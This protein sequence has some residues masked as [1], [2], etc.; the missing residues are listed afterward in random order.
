MD[1]KEVKVEELYGKWYE[2]CV[3]GAVLTIEENTM[4]YERKDKTVRSPYQ[5]RKDKEGHDLWYFAAKDIPSTFEQIIYHPSF[6][7]ELD[8]LS[9]RMAMVVYDMIYHPKNF[10]R[11]PYK[12]PEY[13]EI[14]LN[15]DKKAIKWFQDYRIRKLKFK[16]QEPNRESGMMAPTPPYFGF[17]SYEIERTEE[18]GGIIRA[19][20][21]RGA[22]GE[23]GTGSANRTSFG[24]MMMANA[25]E[26]LQCPEVAMTPQEMNQFELFVCN[27]KIDQL[28]G[29]NEWQD[30]VPS[31]TESFD[32]SIQFY[33]ESYHARAN[34][35]FFLPD[36]KKEI[37]SL[38]MYIFKLLVQAGLDYVRNEFH[39]TKPMLRIP[40]GNVDDYLIKMDTRDD[41]KRKGE[42][43][44][45]EVS[46]DRAHWQYYN[47]VSEPLK[48]ALERML[49][50]IHKEDE[51]RCA[52]LY[53][54]MAE[55]PSDA[56]EDIHHH[57]S[58]FIGTFREI[59]QKKFFVFWLTRGEQYSIE[60]NGT[61]SRKDPIGDPQ[62]Y[63]YSSE[64]GH[65]MCAAE[66]YTDIEK[67]TDQLIEKAAK[68]YS[69]E[70]LAKLK[71]PAYREIV[72]KRLNTPESEGG[73]GFEPGEAGMMF[74]FI[75]DLDDREPWISEYTVNYDE[76]QDILNPYYAEMSAVKRTV[77][78]MGFVRGVQQN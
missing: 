21:Y 56:R 16:V 34:H 48:N 1:A 55:I 59:Y 14:H 5:F 67:L 71:S 13:G 41:V 30:E 42:V 37:R 64:D 25:K 76:S 7:P 69:Q 32:L 73:I 39:S 74:R 46:W 17:Y 45:Y 8:G 66:F 33:K 53:K 2:Q 47:A 51:A 68:N 72:K 44:D 15:T 62:I 75:C 38:H 10:R 52:E 18:G 27:S 28:N 43:Y 20:L 50:K 23:P 19:M 65:L 4:T 77:S 58:I 78:P 12:A 70:R 54:I 60:I 40:S 49:E 11:Q 9:T 35:I 31:G 36:A 26:G 29:I 3:D 6:N 61:Y 22:G 57:A 24:G 63:C